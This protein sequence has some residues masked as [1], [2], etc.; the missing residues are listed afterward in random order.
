MKNKYRKQDKIQGWGSW[1]MFGRYLPSKY[2]VLS[3]N[4]S[5][6]KTKQ[7]DKIQLIQLKKQK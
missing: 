4:P 7:N 2:K 5:T 1:L 3:S 6:T